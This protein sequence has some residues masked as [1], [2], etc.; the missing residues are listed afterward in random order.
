MT[1]VIFYTLVSAYKPLPVLEWNFCTQARV[2]R[3]FHTLEIVF[4][5]R[6]YPGRGGRH[7]PLVQ[8]SFNIWRS[9]RSNNIFVLICL[10]FY[11]CAILKSTRIM[12]ESYT[13]HAGKQCAECLRTSPKWRQS[14]DSSLLACYIRRISNTKWLTNYTKLEKNKQYIFYWSTWSLLVLYML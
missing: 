9:E 3:K 13:N 7:S 8:K 11:C 4:C 1:K 10:N 12:S 2:Y 6:E 14:F 5:K